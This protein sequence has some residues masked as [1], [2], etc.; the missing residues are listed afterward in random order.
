[1][2]TRS[3]EIY[4]VYKKLFRK[5]NTPYKGFSDKEKSGIAHLLSRWI[6]GNFYIP[7]ARK[8]WKPF[9]IRE[10]LHQ[11]KQESVDAVITTGPPHSTHLIGKELKDRTG[12]PWI[13]DFRDPW[14][15]IHY[16]RDLLPGYFAHRA[17][18]KLERQVLETASQ[19]V[20]VS[21]NMKELFLAKS[22]R[23]NSDHIHVI[24]NGYNE[25]DFRFDDNPQDQFVITYTGSLT[26]RHNIEGFLK[27]IKNLISKGCAKL[28]VRLVGSVSP[29][30]IQMIKEFGLTEKIMLQ[31]F[32]EHSKSLEYLN[33]SSVLLMAVIDT[34]KNEGLVTTKLFEY[35]AARKSIILVGPPEG[36]AARLISSCECGQSFAYNDNKKMESYL[37]GLYNKWT[38]GEKIFFG[39]DRYKDF[40]RKNL[41]GTYSKIIN[42]MTAGNISPSN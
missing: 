2:K 19:T 39:N 24:M 36:E 35:L 10:A 26:D 34:K 38:N 8:G 1:V 32:V 4:S 37:E 11:I 18:L 13:A 20:V 12:I 42:E 6:R 17:H 29:G 30:I 16:Y 14:T 41:A 27:A 31:G 25:K 28:S 33:S 5:E 7:D 15:D 9:A 22:D 40:S 21:S 23:L 3:R